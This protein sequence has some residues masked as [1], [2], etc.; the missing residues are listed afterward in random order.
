MD[1]SRYYKL[2]GAA[3]IG[4]IFSAASISGTAALLAGAVYGIFDHYNPLIYINFLGTLFLSAG[5]GGI[6][7]R[8]IISGR[9]RNRAVSVLLG[10]FAATT[11]LYGSWVS[12]ILAV[13]SWEGLI[14]NPL[15]LSDVIQVFAMMGLWS[16]K[17]HT[18][19]GWELYICWL[20]EAGV[21]Y[22][23]V[24][25]ATLET[26]PPYCEDC[27]ERTECNLE[28]HPFATRPAP[29]LREELE[30]EHYDPLLEVL[31]TEPDPR[32]FMTAS[33]N[34]CPRCGEAAFLRVSEITVT[35]KDGKDEVKE[36]IVVPWIKVDSQNRARMMAAVAAGYHSDAESNDGAEDAEEL[37]DFVSEDEPS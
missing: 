13:S 12:F 25:S 35:T 20:I 27:D 9:I 1:D 7:H 26:Q 16:L 34:A 11:F 10:F 22:W 37:T 18:P 5:V 19:T 30:S 33:I 8:R 29:L 28:K 3:P 6:A 2:S 32:A 36:A 4:G 24:L 14:L 21:I 31:Q 17:N 23:F 15:A